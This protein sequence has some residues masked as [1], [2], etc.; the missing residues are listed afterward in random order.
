MSNKNIRVRT[1]PN[2]LEQKHLKV[3]LDQDFDF[4][5]VLSLS[6]SQEEVYRRFCSDYGV[7]VGRV[8]MNNGVGVPNAKVSIF[9]PL[10]DSENEENT[11]LYPYSTIK[12]KDNE[13]KRYN[14]LPKKRQTGC[15]TPIG[16]FASKSEILDNDEL[17]NIHCKYY[18]YTA[19]TNH[20]GDYMISG[21]PIGTHFVNIDVDLSDIGIYSQRPYDFIKEGQP[22][23]AFSTSTKFK[24]GDDIDKLIQVKNSQTSVNVRP[25]WGDDNECEIGITRLDFDT[26]YNIQPSAIFMGSIFGD[27]EKNS[28]NKIC[29]PRRKLGNLC[30]TITSAGSIEMIRK[31]LDGQ[32]ERF[33][34]EGGRVIN[35][36]GAWAY[37]IPMNL[38]YM[39][40]DE[41]GDLVPSP[42]P[43]R[44]IPTRTRVRF[45]AGM[46]V[47]GGEGR[48]RDRAK[49]LI[50]HNPDN[51][52]DSDYSF[53]DTTSDKHFRDMVWNQVYSV[54][55]FIPRFQK[56]LGID[57]RSFTGIK[58][59]DGC[60]GTHNPFP[61]N[62]MDSDINPL[63]SIL[64]IIITIISFIVVLIN[65]I[66]I[67]LINAIIYILNRILKLICNAVFFIG[68][69]VCNLTHLTSSSKRAK[70][71]KSACISGCDL[72]CKTCCDDDIIPYI[73]CITLDCESESYGPGCIEG[74]IPL[75]WA[76]T[77]NLDHWPNDGHEEHSYDNTVPPG[78]AGWSFCV[79]FTIAQSLNVWEFDFYNDWVNGSLFSFL[80][81]YKNKK[82]GKQKFCEYDCDE[83]GTGVD[84][85]NDGQPDNKCRRNWLVDSCVDGGFLSDTTSGIIEVTGVKS[86]SYALIKDGLI[87]SYEGEL[88]YA[89]YTHNTD[90]KLFATDIIHLG[91]I[92]ECDWL[93]NPKLQPLLTPTSY[94]TPAL[95]NEFD[96][97]GT[98]I[99]S[100]YDSAGLTLDKSLYF[101]INCLGIF[102]NNRTCTN[103][104]RQC[105]IGVGLNEDRTDESTPLGCVSDA[106]GGG[107]VFTPDG[108][109]IIDN[110]DI[111][112]LFIRDAFTKLNKPSLGIDYAS[113]NE[114]DHALFNYPIYNSFR[115]YSNNSV[116]QPING[117]YYFYFGLRPGKTA[118]DLMNNKYFENCV[119]KV[120][121]DFI[122]TGV[123]NDVTVYNGSDGAIDITV[124]GGTEPYTYSWSNG[125]TTE[126]I[127]D[128]EVG[129]YTVTVIDSKGLQGSRSFTV[130]Q[131]FPITC[132]AIPTPV[133][134]NGASDGA[135][136]IVGIG[137]GTGPYTATIE[138][139]S[140]SNS[141]Q[142]QV[143]NAPN[144]TASF[145]G[146]TTGDYVTTVEDS[147]TPPQVCEQTGVTITTP[148]PLVLNIEKEDISCY[149]GSDG[150]ITIS[151]VTGVPPV[152]YSITG[153][154]GYTSTSTN[155][156]NLDS[157]TYTVDAEDNIG[158][159][160]SEVVTITQPSQINLSTSTNVNN[161]TCNGAANGSIQ[162][163]NVIG[164]AGGYS[165]NW[166]GPTPNTITYNGTNLTNIGTTSRPVGEYTV[167]ITDSDGC[168]TFFDYEVKE[169]PVL[170]VSLNSKTNV[171]CNG[172]SDGSITVSASGG[173]PA[174]NPPNG[175]YMYKITSPVTIGPQSSPTFN[176][177]SA[178]TYRIVAIDNNNCPCSP[179]D[180]T[181]TEPTRV[182]INVISKTSTSITVSASGGNGGPYTYYYKATTSAQWLSTTSPTISNLSPNT[183][184]NIYAIDPKNCWSPLITETTNTSSTISTS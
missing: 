152:S 159:T 19:V 167:T 57:I 165:Y 20:A 76:V 41:F 39:I 9:V 60:T 43:S 168:Q 62:R 101:K 143:V 55:N 109:P 99:V 16:T 108:L 182:S 44:G 137:G 45:R 98:I 63:F 68:K 71:R 160:T 70:C 111:D 90:Y 126:D 33:D 180:V 162:L 130:G 48:L 156:I 114:Q 124:V 79:S 91:A 97:D 58:D 46:D 161:V 163:G 67:T 122:I 10:D 113:L 17:L 177:L 145:T 82:K 174:L 139:P 7:V 123:V 120:E 31:T 102:S 52:N 140:P 6:I 80:L 47:T 8:I 133:S 85:N 95:L 154:N 51:F 128:L 118:L 110:C 32:N 61:F 35:E 50:P 150:K 132:F 59:V 138:G 170:S 12:D 129:N 56:L 23:K 135:I 142:S 131:P 74:D 21:V 92:F 115:G 93:G 104:K 14:L 22:K 127:N 37:Q 176:N 2:T 24:G 89:A 179:I 173:N 34:V 29:K 136:E 78:D 72:P 94:K 77:Q 175:N 166:E 157:G 105:E 25:F 106:G 1:T 141:T 65:S 83:F 146:L 148:P 103:I 153:P 125:E 96:D 183:S 144:T 169:P 42:D 13:G 11:D 28:I 73:P 18:K 27:N 149:G 54:K 88:Y 84:G 40:T 36:D 171:T 75:P 30:E 117:S 121:N 107:T 172:G 134:K 184:Y 15:H 64:C 147:S 86:G 69:L 5:E 66:V 53:D 81:K 164:G 155:L 112:N 3:K 119:I 181:L 116:S 38:D 49:Y 158:Q 100:G 4:L 178:N 151:Y 26:K 87:K